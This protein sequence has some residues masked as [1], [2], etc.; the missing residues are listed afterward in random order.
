MVLY[1]LPLLPHTN[2]SYRPHSLWARQWPV[3]RRRIVVNLYPITHATMATHTLT[4]V[5]QRVQCILEP[6]PQSVYGWLDE[7]SVQE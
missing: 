2:V 5:Q 7:S 3:K 4:S 1:A 6:V